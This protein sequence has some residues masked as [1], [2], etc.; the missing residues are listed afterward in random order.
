[1]D[2]TFEN[3]Q[4]IILS[5]NDNLNDAINAFGTV[6][7][8]NLKILEFVNKMKQY[9]ETDDNGESPVYCEMWE[10]FEDNDY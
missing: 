10:C 1:M 9:F 2:K 5:L 8:E 6:V 4:K 7:P 3:E